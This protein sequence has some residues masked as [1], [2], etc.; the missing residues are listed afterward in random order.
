[1]NDESLVEELFATLAPMSFEDRKAYLDEHSIEGH[2]RRRVLELLLSHDEHDSVF[3]ASELTADFDP[4]HVIDT[5][6]GP[7][8]IREQLGEGGMGIVYVAEQSE[9][10]RR[11]VA[12]KVIKPGMDSQAVIARFEAERQALALMDHPNIAK[13]LDAGT[14]RTGHPY[15]V[16]ELVKGI[17]IVQYCDHQNLTMEKRLDLFV[18]VCN[19]IQHAHT[20]GVIHRDL[21]PSNIL[22]SPHDGRPVVKVIDFGVAKAIGQ[23]LTDKSVYTQFSQMIGTPLYMSPEQAELNA[24]DVDTRSDV[25]SLGVLLYELMTGTTPFTR[26]RFETAAFDEIRRIIRDEE[27]PRPST[28]L[29]TLGQLLDSVASLRGTD[30]TR[31]STLVRGDLDWIVMKCLDKERSRRYGT[32]NELG[33][34]IQRFLSDAPIEARPPSKVYLTSKFVRRNKLIVA[35]ACLVGL[36]IMLASI[37]ILFGLFRERAATKSAIV[38]RMAE[39]QQRRLADQARKQAEDEREQRERDLYFSEMSLAYQLWEENNYRRVDEILS[40]YRQV[41]HGGEDLRRFE[42]EYLWK[43]TERR[44]K[45]E[46]IRFQNVPL[47]ARFA[48]DGRAICVKTWGGELKL[49]GTDHNPNASKTLLDPSMGQRRTDD[50]HSVSTFLGGGQYNSS[51][52]GYCEDDGTFIAQIDNMIPVKLGELTEIESAIDLHV[53]FDGDNRLVAVAV[54][55]G[56]LIF[57]TSDGQ[58]VKRIPNATGRVICLSSDGRF[59]ATGQDERVVIWD[60]ERGAQLQDLSVPVTQKNCLKFSP[61]N[62]QFAVATED[63]LTGCR[64]WNTS[65]WSLIGEITRHADAIRRLAYSPDGELLATASR[66]NSIGI[67]ETKSFSNVALLKGHSGIVNCVD[68]APN[69]RQ[70]LSA[71]QDYTVVIWNVSDLVQSNR[72]NVPVPQPGQVELTNNVGIACDENRVFEFDPLTGQELSVLHDG[73][74]DVLSIDANAS[75]MLA[76]GEGTSIFVYKNRERIAMLSASDSIS[77]LAL[78]E[79]GMAIA[80]GCANGR[81]GVG[82]LSSETV[83]ESASRHVGAVNH[84]SISPDSKCIAS[85]GGSWGLHDDSDIICWDAATLRMKRSLPGHQDGITALAFAQD[86][87]QLVSGSIDNEIRVWDLSS[88]EPLSIVLK[89]HTA[90]IRDVIFDVSGQRLVSSAG[91]RSVRI[92]DMATHRQCGGFTIDAESQGIARLHWVDNGSTLVGYGDYGGIRIWRGNRNDFESDGSVHQ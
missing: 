11:K 52:V 24:L 34:D 60:V 19:A 5:K 51:Y 90:S 39:Q 64:V 83:I 70:L 61:D 27:P 85:G 71:S 33:D 29:S 13:V 31:L 49:C 82:D 48:D 67:W 62:S 36:S 54:P 56:T 89:G 41:R 30:P 84:I 46:A 80:Y 72:R 58:L 43:A 38:A 15:F 81:V 79:N 88:N 65:T 26:E 2:V 9:P 22:V 92:W 66:D 63:G 35:G 87:K 45:A 69:G 4:S 78:A 16:M 23:Q 42:W 37:G 73:E 8:R 75:G 44:R 1:M 20:K 17:D 86:G 53:A 77:S 7:Y 74:S 14:T 47:R 6:I 3:D 59:L 25:Y 12:L 55:S 57:R 21:K 50:T 91:D 40:R 28:R 68:F 76:V 10:I 18:S 32:P